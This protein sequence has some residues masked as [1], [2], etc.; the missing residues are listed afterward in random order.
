M[1]E[2]ATCPVCRATYN[3]LRARAVAVLDGRVRAFCSTACKERGLQP[4]APPAPEPSTMA[5]RP[6]RRMGM[7]A[8]AGGLALGALALG[9]GGRLLER[10]PVAP[11]V[12]APAQAL[13][14][15]PPAPAPPTPEQALQMLTPPKEGDSDLWVHPLAGPVRRLPARNTRRFGAA[16]EGLRPEECQGGHCGVDLGDTKGEPVLAVHD[17]VVERVV[18]EE[19]GGREGRFVRVSHKGGTVVSAYMHLDEIRADLRP[20]IP[21]KAGDLIGTIGDTGVVRAGPH[22]H[23]AVSVRP[24]A[25][26]PELYIDPEPLLHLWSLKPPLPGSEP[27]GRRRSTTT[28]ARAPERGT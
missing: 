18:R 15:P 13:A 2:P 26:G 8:I 14:M 17:G 10:A 24:A 12:L 16:R 1:I 19:E 11:A 3:P 28:L 5:V 23:F 7:P 4:D 9:F 6:S 25:E 20:G 27:R 22:L 21:V